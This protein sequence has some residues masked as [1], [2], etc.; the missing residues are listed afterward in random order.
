[1]TCADGMGSMAAE[2]KQGSEKLKSDDGY[3]PP[4]VFSG[5]IG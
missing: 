2:R 1:M 5:V 3:V 4:P